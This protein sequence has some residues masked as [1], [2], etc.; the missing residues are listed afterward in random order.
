ML[1]RRFRA[2]LALA[3]ASMLA[4]AQPGYAADTTTPNLQLTNQEA[5]GNLNT[6]GDIADANFERLDDKLG[7]T[8]TLVT[9]GGTTTLSSSQELVQIIKVTGTLL[10]NATVTFS[11]RGG[12]WVVTNET[13]GDFSVTV[14]CDGQ[15][16]TNVVQGSSLTVYSDGT[17]I[18]SV[19]AQGTKIPG[20]VFD[21]AGASCPARSIEGYG[22]ALSRTEQAPLFNAIGT[23]YG[24]G[25]GFTT[26][27]APDFRGRVVAGED[28]MGGTSANRLTAATSQGLNGDTLGA[29]GGEESHVQTLAEL[30]GHNHTF[31]GNALGNHSHTFT[32]TALTGHTHTGDVSGTT[33][34]VSQGHTHSWSGT[35]NSD[36][37]HTHSFNTRG[38]SGNYQSQ[39]GGGNVWEGS[40]SSTTGSAGSHTHSVS[41]TTGGQSQNHTHTWSDDFTTSS[42]SAGTPA[43]TISSVSAGTPS[44]TISSVGSSNAFNVVQPTII[45]KK[46][47]YTGV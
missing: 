46:C 36:G 7:D 35:T 13:S 27:T 6:W 45:L 43:G 23:I 18:R 41:G 38:D 3:L 29:T 33:S 44:G 30:V 37:S 20:E 42:V 47:I 5:G 16:G 9:T 11:C 34:N 4:I 26:F 15:T 1:K 8:T 21:Y 2:A 22:Q 24:A 39:G 28:D 31:T 32:G 25:D 40:Q 12:L 10:T 19:G 14:N 17:D